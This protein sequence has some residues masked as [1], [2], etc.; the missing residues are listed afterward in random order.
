M[1]NRV[2]VNYYKAQEGNI[3]EENN[4]INTNSS[5]LGMRIKYNKN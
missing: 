2:D 3:L 4:W 1:V 5:V